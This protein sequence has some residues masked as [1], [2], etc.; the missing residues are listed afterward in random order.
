MDGF[1]T[2]TNVVVIATTNRPQD[3]D[4]ALRRPGRFDWEIDFPLPD[5]EDRRAILEVSAKRINKGEELPHS[6]IAEKTVNWSPAE[7]AAIWSEAAL[8]AV[9]EARDT[10]FSD[11]YIGGYERVA[12]HRKRLS[13]RTLGTGEE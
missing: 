12:T 4:P 7:L 1:S 6:Y 9:I 13:V 5:V 8:L 2:D 10:I 3:L 11:D